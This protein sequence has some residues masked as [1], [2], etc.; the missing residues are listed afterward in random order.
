[1]EG[2]ADDHDHDDGAADD[3]DHD[4]GAA[5]DD[6]GAADDDDSQEKSGRENSREVNGKESCNAEPQV[7]R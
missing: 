1:M 4:D 7:Q 2:V 5:D 3:N 6:D